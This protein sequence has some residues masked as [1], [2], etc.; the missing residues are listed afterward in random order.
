MPAFLPEDLANLTEVSNILCSCLV[1]ADTIDNKVRETAAAMRVRS[2]Q[3][4]L[5]EALDRYA[6]APH[7]RWEIVRESARKFFDCD[8]CF[9]AMYQNMEMRFMPTKV[10]WK[11]DACIAGKCYNYREETFY[12]AETDA[13]AS[14]AVYDALGVPCMQSAAFHLTVDGKVKG[15]IEL[16]NL[17]RD[18]LDLQAKACFTNLVVLMLMMK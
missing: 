15:A 14:G 17:N 10:T 16:I 11:F 13:Q 12:N 18:L 3:K 1:L 8:D 7:K 4:V 9:I 6:K 5:Y 2:V